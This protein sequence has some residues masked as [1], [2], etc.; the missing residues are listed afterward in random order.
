MRFKNFWVVWFVIFFTC[1]KEIIYN[2]KW[3]KGENEATVIQIFLLSMFVCYIKEKNSFK[4][5]WCKEA[6]QKVDNLNRRLDLWSEGLAPYQEDTSSNPWADRTRCATWKWTTLQVSLLHWLPRDDI[7]CL[8]C[9]LP[10]CIHLLTVLCRV[11]AFP[12]S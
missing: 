10:W 11:F 1:V 12:P 7:F 8:R 3:E 5:S 4:M 9:G 6:S 2:W